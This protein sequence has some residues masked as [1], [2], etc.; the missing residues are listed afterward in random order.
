MHK[1]SVKSLRNPL[2]S[3]FVHMLHF[4]MALPLMTST[5]NSFLFFQILSPTDF[6]CVSWNS[7]LTAFC[8]P[9]NSIAASS[10]DERPETSEPD[11][12]VGDVLHSSASEVGGADVRTS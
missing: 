1:S 11:V 2:E 4:R 12:F 10:D 6:T 9:A 8:C 3:V 7:C 5:S